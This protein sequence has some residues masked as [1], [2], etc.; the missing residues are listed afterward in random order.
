MKK[1]IGIVWATEQ[2]QKWFKP[3]NLS[4]HG[5]DSQQQDCDFRHKVFL[6]MRPRKAVEN[7][8]KI[9]P[10]QLLNLVFLSHKMAPGTFLASEED[11]ERDKQEIC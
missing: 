10:L 3:T 9:S 5:Q 4:S 6:I 8:E 2:Q 7:M 1:V 11:L